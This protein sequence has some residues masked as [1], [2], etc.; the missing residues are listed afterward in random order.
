MM[1]FSATI[2]L[3]YSASAMAL[4]AITLR[5]L[6]N[7]EELLRE[8]RFLL[9]C[10]VGILFLTVGTLCDNMRTFVGTFEG[11]DHFNGA[12]EVVS[13]FCI[14]NHQVLAAFTIYTPFYF[15]YRVVTGENTKKC[16]SLTALIGAIFLFL[17]SGFKFFYLMP[18][19]LKEKVA[20]E[21]IDSLI[22]TLTATKKMANSLV[23]VFAYQFSMIGCGMVMLYKR[24]CSCGWELTFLLANFFCLPGQALVTSL[25]P[26]YECYGSNFWEQV[27]FASA[28][29]ADL[30]LNSEETR[31]S[32]ASGLD[33]N[34]LR[35][36]G[37]YVQMSD[38]ELSEDA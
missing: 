31:T 9:A 2:F 20:C 4:S 24:G 14:A 30:L 28:V 18:N 11:F 17:W 12:N 6:K 23:C 27:T 32:S 35:K 13:W 22:V 38:R 16:L 37:E 26:Y 1:I 36:G 7:F 19:P 33:E 29:C 21:A 10:R 15:M 34:L 25:G 5:R 8:D 3:M